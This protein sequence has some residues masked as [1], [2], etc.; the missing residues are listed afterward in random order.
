MKKVISLFLFLLMILCFSSCSSTNVVLENGE[1]SGNTTEGDSND[2]STSDNTEIDTYYTISWEVDG[3]IVDTDEVLEGETPTY[4]GKTP[5]KE[6]DSNYT[7]TFSGWDP[8]V[9][10]AT[11]DQTYVAVFDKTPIVSE[12]KT[13]YTIKWEVDGVIVDTDEVLEGETPTYS[14]KTPT[15]EADSNY[16]YTFSGWDPEVTSAT[17]DQTYVAVFDKTP[18]ETQVA[19]FV[20]TF[21]S[22]GGSDVASQ[23]VNMNATVT[24]PEDPT[25]SGYV[26]S[27][28]STSRLGTDVFDF[29]TPITSNITLYAIWTKT[30]E[31]IPIKQ[32]LSTLVSNLEVDP[33]SYIPET[34]QPGYNRVDE[35]LSY[36]F[37]NFVNVSDLVQTAYGEQWNMVV[38]N[39]NQ[40]QTFF[41]VL[42]SI[43]TVISATVTVFNNYID[44]NPDNFNSY[45]FTY[46]TYSVY[47][48]YSDNV[49]TYVLSYSSIEIMLSLNVETGVKTGRIQLSDSNALKYEVSD[50]SYSFAIKYLG[51]RTAYF[52]IS[53]DDDGSIE[54]HI[55]EYLSVSSATLTSSCS[56]FYI[57]DSVAY[58]VGNKA[59]GMT[60][61]TGTIVEMYNVSTGKLIA[62]EVNE[63]L[64]AINYD[65]LW[66][67]IWDVS[68]ITS[69]KAIESSDTGTNNT[70]LVYVNG[71]STVFETKKVGGIS[72]KMFSRRYDIEMRTFYAYYYDSEN[73]SYEE[74]ELEMPMLFVQEDN[75]STLVS[76]ITEQNT[77]LS[78]SLSSNITSNV[79][80]L[81]SNYDSLI[82]IFTTNKESMTSD[83][84][85]EIIGD[86]FIS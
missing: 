64:S 69:V 7:Y 15:K 52:S 46:G 19:T 2:G 5:T 31:N 76:D 44:S 71:S 16:T 47:V 33:Y 66:F 60:A 84:I 41:N 6:A 67:N 29:S 12:T 73:D 81:I 65:T 37:T 42:T 4:S 56:D 72:T 45:E 28:W 54:G 80:K 40:S 48:Q 49:L 1:T 39:L 83:A 57:D 50:N 17:K 22:T 30:N 51:V 74:I 20:V 86:K 63:V 21:D 32:Y 34:L 53:K 35:N 61:F 85:T 75:Y 68:G 59:S 58:V 38:T 10:A 70:H 62:Y 25:R 14:G 77:Y 9:T 18:I 36:D 27:Y 82:P 3:V 78:I 23:T 79:N 26:F 8:E 13:Y 55:Y 11:K 24:E 43:D